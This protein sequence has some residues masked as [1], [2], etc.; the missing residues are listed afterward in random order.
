M[1]TR[2]RSVSSSGCC[3][4]CASAW[5][6]AIGSAC[7]IVAVHASQREAS[8]D[9]AKCDRDIRGGPSVGG[10]PG[11]HM[12]A[13]LVTRGSCPAKAEHDADGLWSLLL[14]RTEIERR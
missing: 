3:S 4:F 13:A 8:S 6:S 14:R 11:M 7:A 1:L 5:T 10:S 2:S 9:E 12:F